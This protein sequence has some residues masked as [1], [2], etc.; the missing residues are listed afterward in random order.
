MLKQLKLILSG[1][2]GENALDS[3]ESDGLLYDYYY[4]R[5]HH[6][7]VKSLTPRPLNNVENR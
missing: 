1:R 3:D 4:K 2:E 6:S 5:I 7:A